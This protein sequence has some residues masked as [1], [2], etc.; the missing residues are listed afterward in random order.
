M[1]P[2]DPMVSLVHLLYI[3]FF[4]STIGWEYMGPTDPIVDLKK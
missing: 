1:G 4:K 3:I 2:I